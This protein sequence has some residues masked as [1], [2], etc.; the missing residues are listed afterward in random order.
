MDEI[1]ITEKGFI[2]ILLM[3]EDGAKS[4]IELKSLDFSPSTILVRLR[5]AQQAGLIKEELFSEGGKKPKI[6]YV[7]TKQGKNLLTQYLPIKDKYLTLKEELKRLEK[8]AKKKEREMKLLLTSVS[9]FSY[10][11]VHDKKG[12]K[13]AQ[14]LQAYAN[15]EANNSL[16]FH[17]KS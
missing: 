8:E 15:K 17:K 5:K 7:L 13:H 10:T 4:F 12:S 11:K 6:K 1:N 16:S 14:K 9:K 3:L 2:D